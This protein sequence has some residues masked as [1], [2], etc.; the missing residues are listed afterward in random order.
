MGATEINSEI[1]E[2]IAKANELGKRQA[3]MKGGNY[4]DYLH[5]KECHDR[6]LEKCLAAFRAG[7]V[8]TDG[9]V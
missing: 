7:M 8:F 5:Y 3:P 1:K 4:N 2:L 9:E 6:I